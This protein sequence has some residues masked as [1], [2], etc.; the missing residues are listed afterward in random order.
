MDTME[1]LL[2]PKASRIKQT[3]TSDPESSPLQSPRKRKAEANRNTLG[4]EQANVSSP[5]SKRIKTPS[6]PKELV[7][8]KNGKFVIDEKKMSFET[9]PSTI[10]DL[11]KFHS[12][13][14]SYAETHSDKVISQ[15]PDEHLPAIAKLAQ[16]SAET[17][18]QLSQRIKKLLCPTMYIDDDAEEEVSVDLKSIREAVVSIAERRNYGL[19]QNIL[20]HDD[21][22][23]PLTP[24]NLCIWRWEVKDLDAMLPKDLREIVKKRRLKRE[25]A[26]QE[27]ANIYLSLPD[28]KKQELLSRTTSA[29][30]K[31]KIEP[32]P[33]S[34]NNEREKLE[35]ERIAAEKAAERERVTAEKAAEKERKNKE[36]IAKLEEKRRKDEEKEKKERAQTRL[37][38]FFHR[39]PRD[40]SAEEPAITVKQE[41]AQLHA[42]NREFPP[43][44]VKQHV[45]VAP[46]N[47]FY[48]DVAAEMDKNLA[49]SQ[50]DLTEIPQVCEESLKY[51]QDFKS[52]LPPSVLRKRGVP[53]KKISDVLGLSVPNRRPQESDSDM[54]V[55]DLETPTVSTSQEPESVTQ[56][57]K[58]K[59]LQFYE[60]VRPPYFGTWT[61]SSKHIS[62]RRPHNKDP[63]QLDY[64]YDSEAEWERDEEG[65]ELKSEDEEDEEATSQQDEE[66][67]DDWLVPE[68]YL[69][70]DEGIE[71]DGD[72]V[73]AKAEKPE[74]NEKKPKALV[75]LVPTI[76]SPTFNEKFDEP[77]KHPSLSSYRLEM[78]CD[79]PFPIN[80]F[81]DN[82]YGDSMAIDT[83]A[84]EDKKPNAS[85][86]A[87]SQK[88]SVPD[89]LIPQFIKMVNGSPLSISKLVDEIKTNQLFQSI[90]KTQ[91]EVKLKEVAV[92]EKRHGPKPCWYVKDE[93]LNAV[94]IELPS[95]PQ[96]QAPSNTPQI[97]QFL[98]QEP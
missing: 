6:A 21:N 18:E 39:K 20:G 34:P 84:E 67:Q 44:H 26:T 23:N 41:D 42:F 65:E 78:L 56:L 27:M 92:K 96:T 30:K 46:I 93:V 69:S 58:M 91:L 19:P 60:D 38:G 74:K 32:T 37:S 22:S 50:P 79:T 29:G 75:S 14:G 13:R 83:T 33:V 64:E 28:D 1:R 40:K 31:R 70:E 25:Q 59:L 16:E 57:Y 94:G 66:E 52:R 90:S 82:L 61:K 2:T 97:A 87:T 5:K 88:R 73:A 81:A 71:K 68:G 95:L 17:L 15:I 3:N 72:V 4:A 12:Y 48:R 89:D 8:L 85:A 54:M 55:Y 76:V 98:I 62:Q 7:S 11:A 43:F 49:S 9:H 35:K 51:L 80:P 36:R 24:E 47:R 10:S 45:S 53:V 86:S 63:D 77:T